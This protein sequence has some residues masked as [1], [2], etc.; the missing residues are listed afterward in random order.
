MSNLY[1]R[2]FLRR[3]LSNTCSEQE[4]ADFIL[5]LQEHPELK[6]EIWMEEIWDSDHA[7][8]NSLLGA[9]EKI[10]ATIRRSIASYESTKRVYQRITELEPTNLLGFWRL[11]PTFRYAAIIIFVLIPILVIN[12][13]LSASH[14]EQ[15][16]TQLIEKATHNGQ[17]L[18]FGL[19]DGTEITLSSNSSLTYPN[20]F[21]DSFRTV[22]LKGQAFFNVAKDAKHPFIVRTGNVSTVILGTS[23]NIRYSEVKQK[24]EVSLVSGALKVQIDNNMLSDA[25]VVLEPGEQICID[26]AKEKYTTNS[27]DPLEITGWKDG[28][29]YFK[30]SGLDEIV[31]ILE[32]WYDVEIKVI[33]KSGITKNNKW[34]Y[35]GQFSNQSLEYVLKGIGFVKGFKSTIEEKKVTIIF[36]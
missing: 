5:W 26:M 21:E 30:E 18:T 16:L 13:F 15:Q 19:E 25:E 17:H 10:W 1:D 14:Q 6:D 12:F 8:N 3:L 2:D 33:D 34:T 11:Y 29:I 20:H 7:N 35:T 22:Y 36:N 4:R 31:K 9:E 23:F 32:S 27:F 24:A 28:I